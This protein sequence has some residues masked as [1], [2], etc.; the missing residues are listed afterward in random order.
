MN[1][2]INTKKSHLPNQKASFWAH[3]LQKA[4]H[5][6]PW[7][8]LMLTYSSRLQSLPRKS[9][10]RSDL[11]L[12]CPTLMCDRVKRSSRT[13]ARSNDIERLSQPG[14][15]RE[16]EVRR[17]VPSVIEHLTSGGHR[18]RHAPSHTLCFPLGKCLTWA[19]PDLSLSVQNWMPALTSWYDTFMDDA[20]GFICI[21]GKVPRKQEC[22][23]SILEVFQIQEINRIATG[24]YQWTPVIWIITDKDSSKSFYRHCIEENV[25]YCWA[26]QQKHIHWNSSKP[27][28]W[29][30]RVFR[31]CGNS[32]SHTEPWNI[33]WK[34]AT[35][36]LV[37]EIIYK[38]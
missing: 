14:G 4:S 8:A 35:L 37:A 9:C 3:H 34:A 1:I 10:R 25:F 31:D 28:S 27:V 23:G 32:V 6:P 17:R 29:Y 15:G 19:A 2:V 26:S 22:C 11:T 20:L 33:V 16:R 13:A 38:Y 18:G 12:C 24:F 30:F 5:L 36:F 7:I 21:K